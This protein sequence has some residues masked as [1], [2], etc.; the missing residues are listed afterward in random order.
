MYKSRVLTSNRNANCTVVCQMLAS[1]LR[2]RD[3]GEWGGVE[4]LVGACSVN[5]SLYKGTGLDLR[6]E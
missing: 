3:E 2:R 6:A 1:L 4:V 5:N